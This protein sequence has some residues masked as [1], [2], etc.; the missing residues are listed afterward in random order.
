VA[1]SVYTL[2]VRL[3]FEAPNLATIANM[4]VRQ[5]A[6]VEGAARQMDKTVKDI[7][8]GVSL[9]SAFGDSAMLRRQADATMDVFRRFQLSSQQLTINSPMAG[10]TGTFT[11]EEMARQLQPYVKAVDTASASVD[12]WTKRMETADARANTLKET[13]RKMAYVY[14]ERGVPGTFTNLR[15]DILT[16]AVPDNA[17]NRNVAFLQNEIRRQFGLRD[18]AR[19]FQLNAAVGPNSR[20]ATGS[21]AY[22]A[23][24]AR[25]QMQGQISAYTA[26]AEAQV[27]AAE[28]RMTRGQNMAMAGGLG[29]MVSGIGLPML[30]GAVREASQYQ[31]LQTQIQQVMRAGLKRDMTGDETN[32]MF[33]TFMDVGQ[34]R[35]FGP[36]QMAE[37][38]RG[39]TKVG[40]NRPDLMNQ[41]IQPVTD[42]AE[43]QA[44]TRNVAPGTAAEQAGKFAHLFGVVQDPKQFTVMVDKL[45]RTS[46]IT[47]VTT[48]Q[49]L[50]TLSYTASPLRNMMGIHLNPM[51]LRNAMGVNL[52]GPARSSDKRIN[53]WMSDEMALAT[54]IAW[55]GQQPRGGSQASSMFA[56]VVGLPTQRSSM[57]VNAMESLQNRLGIH[58]WDKSGTF[59][60][61]DPFLDL[62]QAAGNNKNPRRAQMA[63]QLIFGQ[64]GGHIAANMG[65]DTTKQLMKLIR[66]SQ[67]G[68]NDAAKVQQ[69]FN[70]T[71]AGSYAQ[72]QA[73]LQGLS[74]IIG[75]Q[76]LPSLTMVAKAMGGILNQVNRFATSSVGRPIM[77]L[78]TLF[79][80]FALAVVAILSPFA[81]LRGTLLML[82]LDFGKLLMPIRAVVSGTLDFLGG[83]ALGARP[84]AAFAAA[85]PRIARAMGFVTL[86]VRALGVAF[87]WLGGGIVSAIAGASAPA[88][89][90]VVAGI[91]L[92]A[93]AVGGLILLF[94]HW[95]EVTSFVNDLSLK[96]VKLWTDFWNGVGGKIAGFFGIITGHAQTGQNG[97][98][99]GN[100]GALLTESPKTSARHGGV[101]AIAN[102]PNARADE[103]RTH[104]VT[105][106]ATHQPPAH[107]SAA[108]KNALLGGKPTVAQHTT[109]HQNAGGVTVVQNFPSP[110]D[111]YDARKVKKA[112][113]DA[114]SEV[115][116][117]G[118]RYWGNNLPGLQVGKNGR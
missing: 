10:L 3:A 90:P 64:V 83:I 106:R 28:E 37:I 22:Q 101:N 26:A 61:M 79:S 20:N 4:A 25:L 34:V 49:I 52:Q 59:V 23:E 53:Q 47:D 110:L 97:T 43:I 102:S 30:S 6:S 39:L 98:I 94:T 27:R 46:M 11:G 100:A 93:L 78:V 86:A 117:D 44:R 95:K 109:T 99:G 70:Q 73:S 24:Q 111:A 84:L 74:I 77:T 88:W 35:G 91:A 55:T 9:S 56:R 17:E 96:I 115:F 63:L 112:T 13:L 68:I 58:V 81:I 116:T 8:L 67:V 103:V 71:G 85:F 87:A 69:A 60:G 33:S 29:M 5:F 82:G 57:Q 51:N 107:I 80:G 105:Q 92:V 89:L 108:T 19:N 41:I 21:A 12:S 2:A 66:D 75:T 50:R 72:L 76:L 1:D 36:I 18:Q 113:Q 40:I 14:P 38:A 7:N 31:L 16:Q 65:A 42:F 48:D 104:G 114:L 62:L 32:Q 15:G 54:L 118:S 45:N